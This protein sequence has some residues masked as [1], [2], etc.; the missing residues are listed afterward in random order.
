MVPSNPTISKSTVYVGCDDGRLYAFNISN[1]ALLWKT[2][3]LPGAAP[4][5]IRSSPAVSGNLVFITSSEG[6]GPSDAN[7][8]TYAFDKTTGER[9]DRTDVTGMAEPASRAHKRSRHSVTMRIEGA[10]TRLLACH[11]AI[12][13]HWSK[14]R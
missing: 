8:H 4:V 2:P 9:R 7:G 1:G 14:R 6:S 3:V 11:R 13:G 5:V 12:E 10:G